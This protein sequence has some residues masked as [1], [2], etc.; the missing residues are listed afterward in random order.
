MASKRYLEETDSSLLI[1][2]KPIICPFPLGT[3]DADGKL[4][5]CTP[6]DHFNGDSNFN[7]AISSTIR[8]LK[9]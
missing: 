8:G 5:F 6:A 2:P 7:K 3:N 1:A 4:I 9:L